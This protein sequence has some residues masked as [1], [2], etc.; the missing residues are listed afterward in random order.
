MV[1]LLKKKNQLFHLG[2]LFPGQRVERRLKSNQVPQIKEQ[3]EMN[4]YREIHLTIAQIMLETVTITSTITK[5][6]PEQGCPGL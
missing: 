6:V 2:S 5:K 1:V 3:E 4:E